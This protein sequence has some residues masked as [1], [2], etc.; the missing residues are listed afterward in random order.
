[1]KYFLKSV[2]FISSEFF[3]YVQYNLY[4]TALNNY[5]V[6]RQTHFARTCV[7]MEEIINNFD[8]IYLPVC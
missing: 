6:E 2:T 5:M 1:M 4:D 7:L 3:T 8:D